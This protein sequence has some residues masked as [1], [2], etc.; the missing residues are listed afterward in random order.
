MAV[1]LSSYPVTVESG[2][3]NNIFA[4]FSS[5]NIVLNRQDLQIISIAQGVDDKIK[6]TV[7]GDLRSSLIVNEWIYLQSQGS[8]FLY[9]GLYKISTVVF[10]TPNTEITVIG[11]Y[12][13]STIS[14]YINYKQNW[15]L[16]AKIVN[17]ENTLIQIYPQILQNDGSPEG[18]IDIDITML[19]DY[20][21][22]EIKDTSQEI[23]N[24]RVQ[25]QMM[26]REVYREN[27][28]DPF[29]LLNETP[30]I[31][32]FAAENSEIENIVNGF[33]EP[34]IYDGYPFFINILH[35]NQNN[36]GEIPVLQFDELDINKGNLTTNNH[37]YA[38]NS[39]DYGILQGNFNNNIL[40]ISANTEYIKFVGLIS[41]A[42]Y[43]TYDYD[44]DD[45]LT[46]NTP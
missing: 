1:T 32:I 43:A 17:P 29:I 12:I 30:I 44:D 6:I 14:G 26:Y 10:V 3:V 5:C 16:E 24:A 35:S 34:R 25:A 28:T 39:Y 33:D 15:Y 23:L 37:I 27:S 21:L 46:I 9:I 41:F 18:I 7:L 2:I 31:I 40:P 4:G 42:D 38:F 11:D 8:S 20:L 19:V 45:Y 36:I 13:E 22:N